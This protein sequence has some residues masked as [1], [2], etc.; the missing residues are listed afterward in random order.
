MSAAAL[1]ASFA[2]M[3]GTG[4]ASAEP[5]S[6]SWTLGSGILGQTAITRTI[7][8]GT[9]SAGD[10][11]TVTSAFSRTVSARQVY[12]LKDI[13]PDCLTYV[14]GSAKVN[15]TAVSS[16]DVEVQAQDP[17]SPG[18][19]Y[20]RISG[21]WNV[22]ILA[23]NYKTFS[24]D[25][26]VGNCV[27]GRTYSTALHFDGNDGIGGGTNASGTSGD[28]GP[29][30]TIPKT[31]TSTANVV[32]DPA[33][34]RVGEAATL[35]SSVTDGTEGVAVS[36]EDAAGNVLCSGAVASDGS[37]SCSWTPASTDTVAVTAHYPGDDATLA[38]VSPVATSVT[39]LDAVPGGLTVSSMAPNPA[40]DGAT[41]TVS[42][43]VGDNTTGVSLTVGGAVPAG[44]D[45]Q[46]SG[47]S[48][49]C[50]FPAAESQ[51]GKSVVVTPLNG[52]QEGTSA[53]AGVLTVNAQPQPGE[54]VITISPE[55]P[56]AGDTVTVTVTVPDGTEGAE[57]TV[58][59]TVDGETTDVCT[60]TLSGNGT[61]TCTWTPGAEGE[62]TLTATA[63]SGGEAVTGTKH[64]NVSA[65]GE[66]PGGCG[67][68]GSLDILG[69]LG[70]CGGDDSGGS[71]GSL[72][73]LAFV[74][75]GAHV[76]WGS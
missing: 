13:A 62:Y 56:S 59:A 40:D 41:V 4:T 7:S 12:H 36:F 73:S 66:K 33:Q 70:S 61:A 19:G 9:P 21:F 45:C 24:F 32:V 58:T 46:V 57:V 10:T 68:L 75:S 25:Y 64:V 28:R 2:A 55:S 43:T 48:F 63:G 50:T 29:S 74:G 31:A 52:T 26:T 1:A 30:I 42:G 11:I 3:L 71:T 69:S 18:N 38:S 76:A 5:V 65:G 72:G 53:D 67:S 39:P 23:A 37:V 14:P 49:T 35:S 51:N 16:G 54:P 8:N 47:S 60:T 22:G 20:V 17:A 6:V 44:L 15:G 34:P 27:P